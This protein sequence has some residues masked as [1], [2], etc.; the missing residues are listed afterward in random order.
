MIKRIDIGTDIATIGVWDPSCELTALQSAKFSEVEAALRA[1]AE[2]G[3]LFFIET[4]ADGSFLTDIYVDEQPTIAKRDFYIEGDREFLLKS[5][6]GY[7]IAGGVEDFI[8]TTKQI[9][10]EQDRFP[11]TPGWYALRMYE[12]GSY[13]EYSEH[14]QQLLGP[15]DFAYYERKSVGFP[16]GCLPI[17]VAAI[18]CA[19]QQWLAAGLVLAL[20]LVYVAIRRRLRAADHRFQEIIR[21]IDEFD[22]QHPPFLYVLRQVPET[23]DVKG[24]WYR[25]P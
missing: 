12:L 15:E 24:G 23:T 16:W 8:S 4:R 2:A 21:R 5:P 1:E 25:L 6:S 3:R 7:L 18:C 22:E 9:T 14:L 17:V 13:E 19:A 11:V 20:G 10:A